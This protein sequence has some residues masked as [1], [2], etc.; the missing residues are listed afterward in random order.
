M[1]C[2]GKGGAGSDPATVVMSLAVSPG[3]TTVY[4]TPDEPGTQMY[5]AVA[6]FADG[7]TGPLD[8]VSWTLSNDSAGNIDADGTFTST[9]T[10]GAR[11]SVVAAHNG[12]E[13]DASLTVV[14]SAT[15]G[16]DTTDPSLFDADPAGTMNWLYPPDG[17]TLPRNIPSLTLMWEAPPGAS[18]Y[19]IS[20]ST[21][22][23][24]YDVVTTQS[25]WTISG[26]EWASV[27]ATNAGGEVAV[28]VR[29]LVGDTVVATESRALN[30]QRLDA[31]GSIYYWSTTDFGIV[32]VPISAEEPEVYYAP[33]T[34][35][36][37]CV[38]C[39]VVREDRMGVA[40]GGNTGGFTIGIADISD[41][42]P[43]ELTDRSTEGYYTTMNPEGTRMITTADD[44]AL[45]LWNAVTGELIGPIDTGGVKL[46]QPD[47]SPDGAWLV[48]VA[49]EQLFGDTNFS[50]GR[51]V[52][53][54]VDDDG[55]LGEPVEIVTP[56]LNVNAYY[57][58][59]S[60]DGQWIAF[61]EASGS[62]YY[63][64]EATLYV[65]SVDGGEPIELANANQ[66]AS[67]ANSWPHWGPL[68]DDDVFWLTYS[69]RRPYGDLVTDGRP[70]IWVSAFHPERA[71]AG[72]DP[73]SPA[74]WLP[75]QDME[76]SNHSTFWGP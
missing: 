16:D 63:N 15:G 44:G 53:M 1:A 61:N 52:V 54:T 47:W 23:T 26:E 56:G 45:N 36:P 28:Q 37:S 12:V 21:A 70:Q 58:A 57:P 49:S 65:V 43:V 10:N 3:D 38:A 50:D 66:G 67:L 73:S 72:E 59:W 20:F 34:G 64:S 69:S 41:T 25:R 27:A 29:A 17:V 55:N 42:E 24:N 74:F 7:S 75:N 14:W 62:S 51:I 8:L 35:A 19:R 9:T 33:R 40:Y 18:S 68:P 6:T 76:T 71:E 2:G 13:A 30:V 22:T 4:A 46:T 60:P 32:K 39:H 48:A 31:L 11:T 5:K